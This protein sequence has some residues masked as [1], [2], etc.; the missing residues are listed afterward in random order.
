MR[1]ICLVTL[2]LLLASSCREKS[3]SLTEPLFLSYYAAE[4]ESFCDDDSSFTEDNRKGSL[5]LH[6]HNKALY[7]IRTKD[8]IYYFRGTYRIIDNGVFCNFDAKYDHAR[9]KNGIKPGQL[10]RKPDS[11]MIPIRAWHLNLLKTGCSDFIYY[12]EKGNLQK[13]V[14][15]VKLVYRESDPEI[16]QA[17]L[18]RINGIPALK[19]F[20]GELPQAMKAAAGVGQPLTD[21]VEKRY[22]E[23]YKKNCHIRRSENDS[24]ISL[25]IG[26]KK[27]RKGEDASP[28]LYVKIPKQTHK[29]LKGDMNGDGIEDVV[30][31]PRLTQ[32][33]SSSWTE[34]FVFLK[35][36]DGYRFKT[37]AS[38]YDLA[39]YKAN[40]HSC[41]FYPKEIRDGVIYGT[42]LCYRDDDAACCPSVK[43]PTKV[44][45][46]KDRLLAAKSK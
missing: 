40:S 33:G 15:G 28:F 6:P 4:N 24:V 35:T 16:A 19:D 10:T 11:A 5:L 38:G 41:L 8:S 45:L 37:S 14:S 17:Y 31:L 22:A 36:A 26:Y 12:S 25:A 44:R 9:K 30:V 42:S 23:Q 46:E 2:G 1:R 27:V 29:A 3:T 20:H 32:G 43:I 34:L 7:S 13:M 21:Q 39:Q 18:G